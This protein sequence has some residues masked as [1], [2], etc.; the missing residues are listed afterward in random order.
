MVI[1]IDPGHGGSDRGGGSHGDLDEA[2]WALGCA[3]ILFGVLTELG[4][5]A[6]L[7]RDADETMD[8]PER[9]RRELHMGAGLVVSIHVNSNP[10]GTRPEDYH[11]AQVFYAPSNKVGS[12]VAEEIARRM[13]GALKARV[14]AATP[15]DWPNVAY[16]MRHQPG[17]SVLI[18][19][20]FG[21]HD[22]DRT[23]LLSRWAPSL[24]AAAIAGG[25]LYW[26]E[27]YSGS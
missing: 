14:F 11:G 26:Q 15:A 5:S 13:P 2:A 25:V 18:E 1:A 27:H 16:V 19:C 12:M 20:G 8:Q 6:S 24:V 7:V 10:E 22:Y 9:G 23:F 17:V 21:T 4:A 3:R